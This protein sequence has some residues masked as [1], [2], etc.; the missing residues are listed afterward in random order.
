[1]DR[2]RS[3]IERGSRSWVAP[4]I[5]AFAACGSEGIGE[6]D[7]VQ[8]LVHGSARGQVELVPGW[9]TLEGSR[10]VAG[11]QEGVPESYWL[12]PN[13]A[14][15]ESNGIPRDPSIRLGG[16][17]IMPPLRE[18]DGRLREYPR[19]GSNSYRTS[20]HLPTVALFELVDGRPTEE[21]WAER[22]WDETGEYRFDDLPPGPYVI[23][24]HRPD[25]QPETIRVEVGSGEA[26]EIPGGLRFRF[27][28][29]GFERASS[30][31]FLPPSADSPT[32]RWAAARG[33]R[34]DGVRFEQVD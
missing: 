31:R 4:W 17:I 16:S 10:L 5:A 30:P 3:G 25:A 21:P 19:H 32:H 23:C 33:L 8:A 13:G 20:Y 6:T 28:D 1:M 26:V 15:R 12:L 11:H 34:W 24:I 9:G 14:R 27:H 2:L 29:E 22:H 7:P 18:A